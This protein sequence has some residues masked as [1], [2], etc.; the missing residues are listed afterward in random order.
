MFAPNHTGSMVV[1]VED[2]EFATDVVG[3]S[4]GSSVRLSIPAL[5]LLAV[6]DVSNEIAVDGTSPRHGNTLWKVSH[7][8]D[9]SSE[10]S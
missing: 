7:L 3:E 8:L 2:L 6:D 10:N 9:A 1:H 4:L 5:A